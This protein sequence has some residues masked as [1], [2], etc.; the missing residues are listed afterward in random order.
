M[1][2]TAKNKILNPVQ[3]RLLE[4][5]KSL[6]SSVSAFEKSS[7]LSNG[8]FN[9][10]RVSIA[11]KSIEKIL[12]KYPKLNKIWLLHG[13]GQMLLTEENNSN[14]LK[15]AGN[16]YLIER[17]NKKNIQEYTVPFYDA[18]ATAGNELANTD[19]AITDPVGTISVGH[20]L[21]DAEAA[22]RIYGNSMMSN[23]PPGCILGISELKE[24]II[25]PGEVYIVET[26]EQR[27]FKRLFYKDDDP[28]SDVVMCYSDNTML[29][30]GG[31]RNGKL[32]YPPFYVPL[33]SIRKINVVLGVVKRN[34]NLLIK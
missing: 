17:R 33:K 34:V 12:V 24:R 23:Y 5:I 13:D 29:F 28:D 21:S 7:D 3:E 22:I 11:P 2:I 15:D 20:F 10:I 14:V 25:Q 27:I 30:E 26:E 32:A 19:N 4:F 6:D 8:F 9:S 1:G 16:S 31:A 18:G